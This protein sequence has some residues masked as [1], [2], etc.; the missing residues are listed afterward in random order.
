MLHRAYKVIKDNVHGYIN[1]PVEYFD[2]IIDTDLF[3]RLRDIEQTDMRTLYPSARHDRFIHS[4]GVFHLGS[5]A[6]QAFKKNVQSVYDGKYYYLGSKA[7]NERYWD[8][9]QIIFELACLLHDCGHAPFSHTFEFLYD[10]STTAKDGKSLSEYL[11]DFLN[12]NGSHDIPID[13]NGNGAPHERMSAL[14]VCKEY[15]A[16]IDEILSSHNLLDDIDIEVSPVELITRMIIGYNFDE[17]SSEFSLI[18]QICN[19]LINLLNSSTID[20]DSLDY[21]V[22]DAYMSGVRNTNLDLDRIIGSFTIVEVS[23]C[24][25]VR[26]NNEQLDADIPDAEIVS[27][28]NDTKATIDD[29]SEFRGNISCNDFVI[30]NFSGDLEGTCDSVT[31]PDARFVC[32][33]TSIRYSSSTNTK[34]EGKRLQCIIHAKGEIQADRIQLSG[35]YFNGKIKGCLNGKVLYNLCGKGRGVRSGVKIIGILGYKKNCLSVIQN[36]INARNYEYQWIYTHPKVVYYSN[37]ICVELLRLVTEYYLRNVKKKPEDPFNEMA[38]IF[39]VSNMVS[40]ESEF[41]V[42]DDNCFDMDLYRISDSDLRSIYHKAASAVLDSNDKEISRL[43]YEY[44]TR[45]YRKS[46]WK[47]YAEMRNFLHD[48]SEKMISDLKEAIISQSEYHNNMNYGYFNKDWVEGFSRFGIMDP[49]WVI[50]DVKIKHMDL[51]TTYIQFKDRTQIFSNVSMQEKIKV[52][53]DKNTLF[54]IYYRLD[55]ENPVDMKGFHDYLK[56]QVK[57]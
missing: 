4:L 17:N 10:A 32:D 44:R 53:N 55:P 35:V 52:I 2:K 24:H 45:H 37:F 46:V 9:L 3:Q 18:Q 49:V 7:D 14:M 39:S 40:G 34:I 13:M 36:V 15:K 12:S 50:A 57:E 43:Y 33:G 22:R 27:L 28:D 38:K 31:S 21:I 23:V 51:K 1:I 42:H 48:F 6:F 30:D 54:Y 5:K 20:V 16:A 26:L 11:A 8:K 47:S 56:G 29:G 25:N 19:C 41:P